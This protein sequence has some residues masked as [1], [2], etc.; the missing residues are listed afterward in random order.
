MVAAAV[1]L[2]IKAEAVYTTF[3]VSAMIKQ[4]EATKIQV[5]RWVTAMTDVA[6][7]PP[8]GTID[9]GSVFAGTTAPLTD[10][11]MMKVIV[12]VPSSIY[13]SAQFRI[14]ASSSAG[15]YFIDTFGHRIPFYRNTTYTIGGI[16][17]TGRYQLFRYSLDWDG[18][19]NNNIW[20]FT[21]SRDWND[22]LARPAGESG[23]EYLSGTLHPGA[24]VNQNEPWNAP[25]T[26]TDSPNYWRSQMFPDGT[27]PRC[28]QYYQLNSYLTVPLALDD[29]TPVVLSP[30]GTYYQTN[31][32]LSLY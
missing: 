14:R 12:K 27:L 32:V 26:Q 31:V 15:E 23:D 21:D 19:H 3:N 17:Y 30:L 1:L 22:P 6:L 29:G 18:S 2:P 4:P 13:S 25:Y 16:T 11:T 9:F 5:E 20:Y 10:K 24:L 7:Y 8:Y 28:V